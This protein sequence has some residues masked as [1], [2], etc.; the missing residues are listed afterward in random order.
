MRPLLGLARARCL[1]LALLAGGLPSS[2]CEP[3]RASALPEGPTWAHRPANVL[4]LMYRQPLVAPSRRSGEPYERGRPEIDP[5]NLRVFVGSSDR[6]LY[7]LRVQDGQVLWRYE[8]L[9]AVQSE[10]LYDPAE[11]VVYFGSNDGALYKLRAA[12]GELLWRFASN[13]EVAR[14][15][16]LSQGKL[17]FVN[18]NDTII[19]VEPASGK[20]LWSQ[21]RAPA[22]GMEVAGHA[23]VRVDANAVYVAFSAGT[24]SAF[25]PDSGRELWDP[26]DLA[27]E[28]EQA[29]GEVPTY[30]DVDT[31]PELVSLDG[32]PVLLVGSYSGGVTALNALTGNQLWTNPAIKSVTDLSL[33][34]QAAHKDKVT[35][36]LYPEQALA[37]ACTGSTG[38]WGIDPR[39]GAEVWHRDL[40]DGGVN[41]PAFISGALLISTTEHGLF[42]LSPKHGAVIDGLHTQTGFSMAPETYGQRAF[43]LSD[44]G[45]LLA[46][47][48]AAP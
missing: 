42:L 22:L 3:L 19:A 2:G 29:L 1:W 12:T 8:T 16:V 38:L 15:P 11:D 4:Q 6:G 18:A 33:W 27:A 14:Q 20:L 10:P 35:G 37:I 24:V 39:T 47:S 45:D 44:S 41:A 46:L 7:A 43:I 26:V 32:D 23:G 34:Q 30:L 5:Q 28:A 31:T 48:V 36:K 21:H 17:F 25:A 9:A 40:P 13:A